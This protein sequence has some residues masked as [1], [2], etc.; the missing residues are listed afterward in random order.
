MLAERMWSFDGHKRRRLT[1]VRSSVHRFWLSV[2]GLRW[3]RTFMVNGV[4]FIPRQKRSDWSLELERC[5]ERFDY[6][7]FRIIDLPGSETRWFYSEAQRREARVRSL[8]SWYK[9][10]AVHH[11]DPDLSQTCGPPSTLLQVLLEVV[12]HTLSTNMITCGVY[13]RYLE[14]QVRTQR[15]QRGL[16]RLRG[17]GDGR[18][19]KERGIKLGKGNWN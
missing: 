17:C 8:L 16:T 7:C 1:V 5:L 15:R 14:R 12:K 2:P 9:R 4:Y 19:G 13:W 6:L 18:W 11:N 10:Y 3:I